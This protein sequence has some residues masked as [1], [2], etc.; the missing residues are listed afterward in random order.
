MRWAAK[1]RSGCRRLADG[2]TSLKTSIASPRALANQSVVSPLLKHS[3]H[4]QNPLPT[5]SS[6]IQNQFGLVQSHS[7]VIPTFLNTQVVLRTKA[8]ACIPAAS[9]LSHAS[10]GRSASTK[11]QPCC[12]QVHSAST[13]L[14][15]CMSDFCGAFIC[16]GEKAHLMP[17]Q[18]SI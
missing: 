5:H 18:N 11:L 6:P 2:L 3:S 1:Q 13:C 9:A 16:N 8:Q 15:L 7:S 10:P 4:S 12:F 14:C 17:M